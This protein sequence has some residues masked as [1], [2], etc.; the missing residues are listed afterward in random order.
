MTDSLRRGT[1]VRISSPGSFFDKFGYIQQLVSST[2]AV[3]YD[4]LQDDFI[5]EDICTY[6]VQVADY[7][8]TFK[9]TELKPA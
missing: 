1:R 2:R 6:R 7:V 3:Y 9:S 4:V 8:L 5:E